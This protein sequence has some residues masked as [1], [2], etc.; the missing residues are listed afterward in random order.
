[1]DSDTMSLYDSMDQELSESLHE[2]LACKT[3]ALTDL[4]KM[5]YCKHRKAGVYNPLHDPPF[6]THSPCSHQI[7]TGGNLDGSNDD[8]DGVPPK[9]TQSGPGSIAQ[10]HGYRDIMTREQRKTYF[11]QIKQYRDRDVNRDVLL[12]RYRVDYHI[13]LHWMA[14]RGMLALCRNTDDVHDFR[15]WKWKLANGG[16]QGGGSNCGPES[17]SAQGRAMPRGSRARRSNIA[18]STR[19]M[20][21]WGWPD[22]SELFMLYQTTLWRHG[23]MARR[24]RLVEVNANWARIVKERLRQRR[25]VTTWKLFW[26]RGSKTSPLREME[27]DLGETFGEEIR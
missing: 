13:H 10:P 3:C 11:L 24:E 1:M 16:V 19:R 8:N 26:R 14:R 15:Q 27:Q 9:T 18:T 2:A 4:T 7:L 22:D 12:A 6:K 5:L 23:W 25:R 21:R 17:S 20:R